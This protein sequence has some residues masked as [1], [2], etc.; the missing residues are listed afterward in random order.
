MFDISVKTHSG[1]VKDYHI[2]EYDYAIFHLHKFIS[3]V[4]VAEVVM[5]NGLTG[6]ILFEWVRGK[7][8][9]FDEVVLG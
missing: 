3:A 9:I 8:G 7:W 4:D 6:E 1:I 2:F 5:T